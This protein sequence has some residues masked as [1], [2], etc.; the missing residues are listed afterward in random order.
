MP[1]LEFSN[2]ELEKQTM[3]DI[4]MIA[5]LSSPNTF[6]KQQM[7]KESSFMDSGMDV[8]PSFNDDETS[9]IFPFL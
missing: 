4:K 9:S 6:A 7:F 5:E 3:D 1:L 8:S 2:E